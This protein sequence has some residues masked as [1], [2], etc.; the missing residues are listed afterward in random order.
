MRR[1]RG[2]H[3]RGPTRTAGRASSPSTAASCPSPRSHDETVVTVEGI[4][5]A[6]AGFIR[7][8]TPWSAPAARSAATARRASS[9][10]CSASTTGPAAT[11]SIRS[12]SAATCAAA[13]ATGRSPTSR[14][15]AAG[16][17]GRR[18]RA[19]AELAAPVAPQ[20]RVDTRR[21]RRAL[22]PADQPRRSVPLPGRHR[23]ARRC[24]PAAPTSWSASRRRAIV[25]RWSSRWTALPELRALRGDAATR[26]CSAPALTLTEVEEHLHATPEAVDPAARPAAAAVLVA[27][28]PQPRHARRQPR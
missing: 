23:P 26:S 15:G 8:R 6:T 21:R 4:A 18:S 1:L 20:T 5:P 9:S 12:R 13:P 25:I 28:D 24:S 27:A 14:A 3:A 19:L 7:S 22:R 11:A 16:A 17:G 2:R 10:A